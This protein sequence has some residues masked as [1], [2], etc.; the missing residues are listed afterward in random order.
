MVKQVKQD[1]L[2]DSFVDECR[3]E[4]NPNQYDDWPE[5]QRGVMKAVAET[6]YNM[7]TDEYREVLLHTSK[8]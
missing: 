1:I 7:T 4:W 2:L 3:E 8:K 5:P 6:F